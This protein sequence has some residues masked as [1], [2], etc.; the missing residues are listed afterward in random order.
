M[1]LAALTSAMVIF[2]S[3]ANAGSIES[4]VSSN[5]PT[6]SQVNIVCEGCPPAPE[7]R[8]VVTNE[9]WDPNNEA[10]DI[11]DVN[12]IKKRFAKEA[13]F[14]GSPT[15]F[16][17]KVPGQNTLDT[18]AVQPMPG[19]DPAATTS[20][21]NDI[22]DVEPVNADVAPAEKPARKIPKLHE[23]GAM[24]GMGETTPEQ[25]VENTKLRN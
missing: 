12:G 20:A 19:V 10:V 8:P 2:A 21:L 16:V 24:T 11:K 17:T 14:G 25:D 22:K 18:A 23:I 13:W 5:R 4:V 9:K 7:M 15:V 3:T 6:P 1:R